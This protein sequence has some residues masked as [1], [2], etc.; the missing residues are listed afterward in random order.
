MKHTFI[1]SL[2]LIAFL[3]AGCAQNG[4]QGGVFGSVNKQQVGAATGAVIGGILGSNVGGGKGKYVAVGVG[5]LLGA[6]A[7]SE[8]GKSLDRADQLYAN[9]AMQQSYEAPIGETVSWANP[10]SG[11][12]G[13]YTPVNE[14][15]GDDTNRYCREYKQEIEVDGRKEEAYGT[16]CQNSDGT[17]Q[18]V[19]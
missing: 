10:E 6:L 15:Y 2:A 13:S 3:V 7:G 18:I 12:S 14:G 1:T 5:T 8:I 9:R 16:A 4:N 19:G 17:W 11:N